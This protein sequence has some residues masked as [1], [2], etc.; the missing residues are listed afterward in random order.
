MPTAQYLVAVNDEEQYSLWTCD[1]PLP[2]GWNAVPGTVGKSKDA[3]VEWVDTNW[4]DMRPKSVRTSMSGLRRPTLSPPSETLSPMLL[5]GGSRRSSNATTPTTSSG[6]GFPRVGT[7][8]SVKSPSLGRNLTPKNT[9]PTALKTP[10]HHSFAI[11][12]SWAPTCPPLQLASK[13]SPIPKTPWLQEFQPHSNSQI[14]LFC[15][16]YLGGQAE[17]VKPLAKLLPSTIEV[18]GVQYPGHGRRMG[19]EEPMA[20]LDAF[21]KQCCDALLPAIK[22]STRYAFMGY[23]M[24]CF[25]ATELAGYLLKHHNTAPNV[26]VMCAQN[27]KFVVC[28]DPVLCRMTDDGIIQQLKSV[29]GL[30]DALLQSDELLRM[31]LPI[32]RADSKL[33]EQDAEDSYRWLSELDA[34]RVPTFSCPI[35]AYAGQGERE[36]TRDSLTSWRRI[37]DNPTGNIR[38]FDGGHFF[39]EKSVS[40]MAQMMSRDI[41]G[42]L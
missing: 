37:T 15:F 13:M 20:D 36:I 23:S 25:L 5:M 24:G 27:P 22:S 10:T 32:Y 1:T 8:T 11:D 34:G 33:T 2:D 29:G 14:R 35:H 40:S 26:M 4:T 39:I 19:M 18:V 38:I 42:S 30:P 7:P 28:T 17:F 31:M 3:C 6:F 41:L 21:L 12:A 16:P 9:T